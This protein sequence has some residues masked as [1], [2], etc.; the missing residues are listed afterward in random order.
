MSALHLHDPSQ[1]SADPLRRARVL[2]KA[3]SLLCL[4]TAIALPAGLAAYWLL[5]PLEAL[6]REAGVPG[7]S[8]LDIGWVGR[9]TAMMI[10]AVPLVCL[11]WG[12][13]QARRCFQAF[14]AGRFFTAE[15]IYG[16]RGFAMA[17]FASAL[18]RPVA[19]A[20]LSV[21]LSWGAGVG[22]RALVIS[23][24]SDTLL[25]LLFAGMIV[26]ITWVMTEARSLADENAQFV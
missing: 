2:S 8:V 14:A 4:G 19:G 3:M 9:L 21:L 10:S 5:T 17:L 7:V 16:L 25:S 15:G 26:I 18:L 11:V 22:K 1:T 24:G 23:L 12:L 6:L 13:L 20:A